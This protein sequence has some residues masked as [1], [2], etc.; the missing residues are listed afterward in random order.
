MRYTF[1]ILLLLLSAVLCAQAPAL[2]PYQA[3]A[4]DAAGQPLANTNVNARFTIHDGSAN[5]TTVWQELQTVSTSALGLFTVQLGS[6]VS[7]NSVNWAGGAKFMQVEIDLGSGFV[8]IGTQQML[9]V[10]YALNA[11]NGFSEIS[12]TGDTLFLANGSWVIVPYVSANN[13]NQPQGCTFPDACNYNPNATVNDGSCHFLGEQCNDEDAT[14]VSDIWNSDCVCA[15]SVS[16]NSTSNSCGAPS[17]HNSDVVHGTMTDQQGNIYRTVQYGSQVWMAENLK[18]SIYRN[19]QEISIASSNTEWAALTTGAWAYPGGGSSTNCM[20]GKLYN[21][22]AVMDSRNICPVGW[23]VPTQSEWDIMINYTDASASL[24]KS[25]GTTYWSSPNTGA[26][27][28]LG[29][30]ALP[31]GY[32]SAAGSYTNVNSYSYFWSSTT[33]SATPPQAYYFYLRTD[34]SGTIYNNYTGQG[35]NSAMSVRCVRD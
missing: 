35:L 13:S 5:G 33:T 3:V 29:F 31:A 16:Q 15:G 11:G 21:Y 28:S 17:V 23:H 14:T 19:G 10:P 7:L 18:T 4:R 6:N 24:L 22:F 8:D 20:Y 9:S 12:Q 32:R 30:S 34:V 2:I 26:T 1:S 27:N 25:A